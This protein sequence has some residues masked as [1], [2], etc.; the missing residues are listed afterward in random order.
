MAELKCPKC[1]AAI[2]YGDA[3]IGKAIKCPNCSA[4]V[5]ALKAAQELTS[6]KCASCGGAMEFTPGMA[7]IACPFCGAS[8]L[9]PAYAAAAEKPDVP[10]F[11][12]PF[13][14]FQN[15][16]LE[17]LNK[18]LNEGMFTAGDADTAAAVT[19]VTAKYVPLYVCNCDAQ[20]NWSGQYSTTRYRTVTRTRRD[21][22][23]AARTYQE[24]EPYKEWHATSG[25]H[26]GH[27]RIAV[28]ASAGVAQEDLDK[29]TGDPANFTADEGA[30]PFARVV[31]EDEF[32]VDKPGIDAAEAKRR[33]KIKVEALERAA[34]E[35]E[36]ERLNNC[37]SALSNVTARVSYHPLWW[38]DYT[39]KGKAYNCLMDGRTGAVTGKKPISK[40]KVILAIV[41]IAIILIVIILAAVCIGG[42]YFATTSSL[43]RGVLDGA[44]ALA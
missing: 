15:N 24:Q 31:R 22:Q 39:Y 37:S 10:E 38:V 7:N 13:K 20:S 25:S 29:L 11:L 33:V 2:T 17:Y 14:I 23:G 36:V 19:R 40:T 34:C 12:A 42:G 16:M 41:I 1:D 9:L 30:E 26:N 4:E 44:L 43:L 3:D 32:P 28:V 5:F 6:L 27:Y 18:W 8:Y 21:A 35:K